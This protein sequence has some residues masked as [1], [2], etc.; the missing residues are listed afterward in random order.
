MRR[1]A[2]NL[3]KKEL[4]VIKRKNHCLQRFLSR[5]IIKSSSIESN[6]TIKRKQLKRSN[7]ASERQTVNLDLF[8]FIKM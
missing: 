2:L 5:F 4:K 7:V 8:H 6:V 3:N 1:V